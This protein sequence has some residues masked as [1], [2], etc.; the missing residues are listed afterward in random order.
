M[1]KKKLYKTLGKPGGM[2]REARFNDR[3][4]SRHVSLS[5]ETETRGLNRMAV[6][7]KTYLPYVTA[8]RLYNR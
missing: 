6:R 3:F 4:N 1:A 2:E 8:D 7:I 5:V